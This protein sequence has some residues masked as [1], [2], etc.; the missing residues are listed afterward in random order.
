MTVIEEWSCCD[1]PQP[2][3]FTYYP[4]VTVCD[5]CW[6]QFPYYDCWCELAHDCVPNKWRDR[7]ND[8]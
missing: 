2:K 3:G 6:T 5:G 1:A 7:T 8:I 4:F